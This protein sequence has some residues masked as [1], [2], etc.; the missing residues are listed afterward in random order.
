MRGVKGGGSALVAEEYREGRWVAAAGHCFDW[1]PTLDCDW[2]AF[3]DAVMVNC[4]MC[5]NQIKIISACVWSL[6][7]VPATLCQAALWQ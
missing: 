7:I 1:P 6:S 2:V 3:H 5:S 4:K